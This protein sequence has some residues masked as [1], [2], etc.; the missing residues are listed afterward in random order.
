MNAQIKK[1]NRFNLCVE[2]VLEMTDHI[3]ID[4]GWVVQE[5]LSFVF[6]TDKNSKNFLKELCTNMDNPTVMSEAMLESFVRNYS[7]ATMHSA[8]QY[9]ERMVERGDFEV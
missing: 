5:V 9:V 3:Y 6:V 7:Y 8:C 1:H 2:R 4:R